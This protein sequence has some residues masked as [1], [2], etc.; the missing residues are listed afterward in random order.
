MTDNPNPKPNKT[1]GENLQEVALK[2]RKQRQITLPLLSTIN[3]L[4]TG[5]PQHQNFAKT[6]LHQSQPENLL[7]ILPFRQQSLPE[8]KIQEPFFDIEWDNFSQLDQT[9]VWQANK[10]QKEQNQ[11]QESPKKSALKPVFNLPIPVLQQQEIKPKFIP[12]RSYL[13]QPLQN[14]PTATKQTALDI[15]NT[16]FPNQPIT[17]RIEQQ[18]RFVENIEQQQLVRQ[19]EHSSYSLLDNQIKSF[20]GKLLKLRLPQT[21]KIYNNSVSDSFAKKL[22]ADAL[23]YENKILFRTGKYHFDKPENM[24]ILGHELTHIN[25]EFTQQSNNTYVKEEQLALSNEQTVINYLA[26]SQVSQTFPQSQPPL[27]QPRLTNNSVP[28]TNPSPS[29]SIPK[30]AS[31]SRNLNTTPQMNNLNNKFPGELSPQQLNMIKEEVYRDLIQ[32][33]RTEFERGS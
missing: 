1:I 27:P 15:D 28:N 8:I 14:T 12:K 7:T 20:L 21:V 22:D 32:R 6:I 18:K 3:Y 17:T 30:T 23:T 25:Q 26:A 5:S 16:R 29:L 19:I 10:E 2:L 4:K 9:Q 24:A 31:S 11:P 33:I 13:P